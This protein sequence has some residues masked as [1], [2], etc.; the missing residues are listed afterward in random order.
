MPLLKGGIKKT[1]LVNEVVRNYTIILS[2][3]NFRLFH[4]KPAIVPGLVKV[5]RYMR[6]PGRLQSLS[7]NIFSEHVARP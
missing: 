1:L 4:F 6:I 2:G 5:W 3:H 7:N